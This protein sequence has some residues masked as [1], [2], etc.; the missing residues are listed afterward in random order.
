[1]FKPSAYCSLTQGPAAAGFS[2]NILPSPTQNLTFIH[3][4]NCNIWASTILKVTIFTA[5]DFGN[6]PSIYWM[7]IRVK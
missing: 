3:Y 1:M 5:P 4:S 7:H 2:E 6:M